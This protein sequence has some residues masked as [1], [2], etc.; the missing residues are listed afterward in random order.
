MPARY[1]AL[2]SDPRGGREDDVDELEAAFEASDD[3]GD[4]DGED[5]AVPTSLV[6]AL[7]S[8]ARAGVPLKRL[9]FQR[10][11]E[12]DSVSESD[13]ELHAESD[14]EVRRQ[15][16]QYVVSSEVPRFQH[17]AVPFVMRDCWRV[18]GAE[19]YWTLREDEQPAYR[20]QRK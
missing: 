18:E 6:K 9:I 11:Y 20:M 19:R 2:P 16:G 4:D 12:D 15:V 8:R 5:D 17:A 14:E 7:A 1:A 10:W 3:E 13:T